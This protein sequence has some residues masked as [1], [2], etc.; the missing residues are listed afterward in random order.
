ME[1]IEKYKEIVNCIILSWPEYESDL[2]A[3][4][5]EKCL[6]YNISMIY[7]GEDYGGCTADDEFFDMMGEKCNRI[8]IVGSYVPFSSIHDDIYLVTKK[9][10]V[11]E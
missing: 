9:L 3:R 4:V 5:L 6:E 1:A 2:A 11:I 8:G 7:I 10:S